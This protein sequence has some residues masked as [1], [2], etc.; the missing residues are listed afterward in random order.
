MSYDLGNGVHCPKIGYGTSN[1][2]ADVLYTAIVQNNYRHLDTASKYNNEEMI[3]E[4]LQKV[5]RETPI[6]RSDMFIVTKCWNHEKEDIPKAL[7]A[8]LARLKLD[9]VDLYLIHWP[10]Q[11][12]GFEVNCMPIKLPL[13]KQW[14][15]M[16]ECQLKGLTRCIGVSN[17]NFQLLNDLLTYAKIRPVANQIE[18]N[19]YVNQF[20]LVEWM[21]SESILP[22][23]Y[24]PI[25][26]R[27]LHT[28]L[29]KDNFLKD[30]LIA[31]LAVKYNCTAAQVVLAW[32]HARGHASLPK[33]SDPLR[34]KQ[35]IE[36]LGI[37][38]EAGD[39]DRVS[40]LNKNY[41]MVPS[42]RIPG[43]GYFPI[44]E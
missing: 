19:P 3:G 11:Y 13:H 36:S 18:L 14:V 7:H 32:G 20:G 10:V 23:A 28:K 42:L 39:V 6:K 2:A 34:Q 40:A 30:P 21:K 24:C 38:L 37:K 29:D 5:F 27:N 4:V 17:F 15:Q 22:I 9:Y 12:S 35:N 43:L 31:E 33:S 41:R 44:F 25:G 26:G 16:E 1:I 8:S